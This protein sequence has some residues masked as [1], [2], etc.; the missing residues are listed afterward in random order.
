MKDVTNPTQE[1]H[2]EDENLTL[3]L[4]VGVTRSSILDRRRDMGTILAA[5]FAIT[6]A[7]QCHKFFELLLSHLENMALI[8]HQK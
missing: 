8:Y 4:D 3:F 7:T 1:F 6:A 2:Q 5:V